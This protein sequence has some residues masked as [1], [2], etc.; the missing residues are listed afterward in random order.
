MID[1]FRGLASFFSKS[2]WVVVT[3]IVG[4]ALVL[5]L[6]PPPDHIIWQYDHSRDRSVI[7][8]IIRDHNLILYGPATSKWGLFHGPIFYYYLAPFYFLSKGGT[9]LPLLAMIALNLSS[10][11]PLAW[12][13]NKLFRDKKMAILAMFL[14]AVS[15]EQV[16]YARWLSNVSLVTPILLWMLIFIWELLTSH[17]TATS[18]L[19]RAKQKLR[20][21]S[22]PFG[23]QLLLMAVLA[24]FCLGLLIQSEIFFLYLIPFLGAYFIWKKISGRAWLGLAV[25]LAL[26]VSPFIIGEFKFGFRSLRSFVAESSADQLATRVSASESVHKYI[27]HHSIM[28]KINVSSGLP[29]LGLVV[30][31]A[32]LLGVYHYYRSEKK[33]TRLAVE[34]IVLMFF[35]RGIIFLLP[36]VEN[37]YINVG[38]GV[39]LMILLAYLLRR[40][41]QDGKLPL[42]VFLVVAIAALQLTE[43]KTNVQANTPFSQYYFDPN[44]GLLKQHFQIMD[45]LAEET[46][47]Q[48]YSISVLGY[49]YGV[50]TQWA[51]VFQLYRDRHPQLQIPI[52][53]GYYA[54]G[55]EEDDY[56]PT[57]DHPQEIHFL[58]IQPLV[59]QF[60]PSY[61]I[62]QHLDQQNEATQIVKEKVVDA[63][64]IQTRM[65]KHK[66]AVEIDSSGE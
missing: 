39:L 24:G 21:K 25:G 35:S 59:S 58:L 18:L 27:N 51:S 45:Y 40:L 29:I 38:S 55:Y 50:R 20:I 34:L 31:V 44:G 43:L 47:G 9:T 33:N 11:I 57:A 49:P 48:P 32:I 65:P 7:Q 19:S 62:Q 1:A 64:R 26:G 5:R 6:S 46:Q 56:F 63:V 61:L 12:L 66:L 15:Y 60:L 8:S 36:L 10:F 42:V 3:L 22:Q 28:T 13:V 23:R 37:I 16:E 54:N 52:W 30:L 53:F 41:G 4:L 14:F 2:E 17:Q